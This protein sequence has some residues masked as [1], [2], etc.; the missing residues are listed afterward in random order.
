MRLHCKRIYCEAG[1]KEGVLEFNGS[2]ITA[3]DSQNSHFDY[4]L[5]EYLIIPGLIDIHTHGFKTYR[6]QSREMDNYQ[7]LSLAMA[8]QGVSGFLVTAGEHNKEEMEELQTIAKVMEQ[9]TNGARILGIHMEGPFLNP[10]KKGSFMDEQ[11][12]ELDIKKMEEYIKQSNHQIKYVSFAPELDK[13]GSFIR[14]LKSQNILVGGVH[15]NA[16]YEEYR[17]AIEFGLDSSAHMGNGMS[18]I[19]NRE[20]NA[21]GA[22]LLDEELYCEIICDMIHLS[23]EML[24]IVLKMKNWNRCMMVSDSG[25]LSG[26]PAGKYRIH[27]QNRI[28]CEDGRIILEDG[29]IAGSSKTLLQDIICMRERLNLSLEDLLRF[30]SYNQAD[31]LN[32]VSDKGSI[33]KGKDADFVIVDQDLNVLATFVEGKCVYQKGKTEIV[34]D[35]GRVQRLG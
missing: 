23:K 17:K 1:C 11:L 12:L 34:Y 21:L 20:V 32:L 31:F 22:S 28:I 29:G 33:A 5:G 13:D 2:K 19:T 3:I 8:S 30:T 16:T 35:E 14:Y 7:M 26:M 15:T 27:H 6:S 9:G 4:E 24:Q 25:Q 18:Q 10:L